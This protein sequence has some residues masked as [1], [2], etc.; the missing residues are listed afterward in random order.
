MHKA[1]IGGNLL[2]D[3]VKKVWVCDGT[4][5]MRKLF[6]RYLGSILFKGVELHSFAPKR[7]LLLGLK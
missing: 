5:V 7:I 4:G 2:Q 3:G 6:N 1:G